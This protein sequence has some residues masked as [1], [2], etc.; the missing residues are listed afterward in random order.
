MA[1][2]RPG[3]PT[4][5]RR[6]DGDGSTPPGVAH[7]VA[8]CRW[9][10]LCRP[11]CGCWSSSLDVAEPVTVQSRGHA[12]RDGPIGACRVGG[13]RVCRAASVVALLLLHWRPATASPPPPCQRPA[14]LVAG[15]RPRSP[16]QVGSAAGSGLQ[17][18]QHRSPPPAVA[19]APGPSPGAAR[20]APAEMARAWQ[21]ALA[22]AI[23]L[24][25]AIAWQGAEA[26]LREGDCQGERDP[27]PRA[28]P[29]IPPLRPSSRALVGAWARTAPRAQCA[30]A[31][32]KR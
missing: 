16:A 8:A 21:W 26:R 18:C 19:V 30:W 32:S 27:A 2:R 5:S 28:P 22:L 20:Q 15:Q 29:A 14:V 6:A 9:Q 25:A 3:S 10:A 24:M 17:A 7:A 4:L 13:P 11:P 1:A 23:T 31:C 12:E